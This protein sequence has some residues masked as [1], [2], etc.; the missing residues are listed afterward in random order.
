MRMVMKRPIVAFLS[1]LLL[2][3]RSR[4]T[5]CAW[6]EAENIFLHQQLIAYTVQVPDVRETEEHRSPVVGTAVWCH[7]VRL[8]SSCPRCGG[9]SDRVTEARDSRSM[10]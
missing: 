9:E 6:L 5:R 4:F 10:V 1:Q 2:S 8:G 3:I 7:R